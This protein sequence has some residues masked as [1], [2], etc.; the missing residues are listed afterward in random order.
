MLSLRDWDHR[1][2][3]VLAYADERYHGS[4]VVSALLH[5]TTVLHPPTLRARGLSSSVAPI[6]ASHGGL[7]IELNLPG[8]ESKV[9]RRH[10]T[11]I[12]QLRVPLTCH[13]AEDRSDVV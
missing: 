5:L 1:L 3:H 4:L 6:A 7:V 11:G 9:D 10:D 12:V 8:E 13:A 2:S